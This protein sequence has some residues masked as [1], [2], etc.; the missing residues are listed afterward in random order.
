VGELIPPAL[1]VV[2]ST[3]RRGAE[4]AAVQLGEALAARGTVVDT[5][6]L[7][8]GRGGAPLDLPMLGRNRR[9]PTTLLA[10][11]RAAKAHSVVVGQGSSTLP[12]GAAAT[13]ATGVPFVYRSIGDP[14]FWASSAPRR[15]RVRLA[16]VRARLVV[17]IWPGAATAFVEDYGVPRER[18]RVIPNGVPADAFA[19]IE[20]GERPAA[21]R[22]LADVLGVS[23]DPDRPLVA[24]LGA[25]SDEKHPLLAVEAM[26]HVPDAQLVLAGDGPLADEVTARAAAVDPG[27]IAAVGPIAEPAA[28]LAAADALV[29][30]SRSEGI[31]AVTIEA[32]LAGLPVVATDVGGVGEVVVDGET[33]RLVDTM[34]PTAVGAAL[35][36]VLGPD[37]AGLGAAARRRCLERFSLDV[38]AARW[39]PVLAE[40]TGT[41]ATP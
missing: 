14:R 34:T 7:W 40:V 41:V 5:M 19:P 8:P 22:A 36:D 26:T 11:R 29:L 21:R 23:I 9:D 20:V 12:F 17:A 13:V 38:V 3:D 24:Y 32:G 1:Q 35:R 2:T 27:R 25:L 33:G 37:G 18:V 4:V 39:E 28:L 16:L 31:P 10:L 30:P 6:A 15:W